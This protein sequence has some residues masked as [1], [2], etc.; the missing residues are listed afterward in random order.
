MVKLYVE[1]GGD[2]S[3]LKTACRKGFSDFIRNAGVNKMPRIVACGA[4]KSA[5]ERYQQAIQQ[6]ESAMLL[7]DSEAAIRELNQSGVTARWRPWEHLKERDGW[8]RPQKAEDR[9]CHLMAQVMESWFLADRATLQKFFGQ[10]FRSNALPG[11]PADTET[12]AKESIFQGL[13][14]ATRDTK[15][16]GYSKGSH[17]FELL[18]RISPALVCGASPWAKRWIDELQIR[19][20]E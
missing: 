4:R 17:S 13:G 7:V 3:E 16:K 15:A 6:G 18:G 5:L 20:E 1:G 2:R 14:A 10:G 11:T 8:Q 12:V 9:D 19:M